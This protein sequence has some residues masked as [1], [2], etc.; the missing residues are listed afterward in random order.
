MYFKT[1]DIL[2]KQQ[3]VKI[4]NQLLFLKNDYPQFYDWFN[5]KVI[6]EV[7]SSKRRVIL[8]STRLN[9]F[10][11]VLILK[12]TATE[13][14][15]CTLYVSQEI[16]NK[17]LGSLFFDIAFEKLKTDKPLI[18]VSDDHIKEFDK[19]LKKYK[20]ILS[21]TIDGYYRSEISEYSYNGHLYVPKILI[22]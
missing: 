22:A 21:E 2:E 19:L 13:K 10:A 17:K 12:N 6:T 11:G 20:F 5:N 14:K 15:I 4:R 16:R 18:T 8:A 3:L 7:Q 1:E 9:D